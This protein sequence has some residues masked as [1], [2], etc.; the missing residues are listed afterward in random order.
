MRKNNIYKGSSDKSDLLYV[1]NSFLY[2][3]EIENNNI[4]L[5]DYDNYEEKYGS[6]EHFAEVKKLFVSID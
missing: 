5:V 6:K 4:F 2:S 3:K 1:D